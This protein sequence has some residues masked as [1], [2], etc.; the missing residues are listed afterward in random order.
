VADTY[1]VIVVGARCAGSATSYLLARQGYLVLLI[2]QA[3]FPSDTLSTHFLQPCGVRQ[4]RQWGLLPDLVATGAPAVSGMRVVI[5]GTVIAGT[6]RT[7]NGELAPGYC[8]RRT[9]LDDLLLRT[10]AG[11]G[12]VVRERCKVTG[13]EWEDDRV[14]G[15]R[16]RTGTGE[17]VVRAPLVVGAD[18]MRSTVAAQVGAD[19]YR[20]TDPLTCVYY[21]YWAGLETDGGELRAA[22][23]VGAGVYPTNDGLTCVAVAWPYEEFAAF[24]ADIEDNFQRSLSRLGDLGERAEA[25]VRAERFR[26]TRDVPNFFRIGAGPGWALVGDAGHHK[27]PITGQGM[28]DAFHDAELL[29]TIADRELRATGRFDGA[30]Y[31]AARNAAASEQH[32]MTCRI[33]VLRPTL[34][35]SAAFFRAVAADQALAD[36]YIELAGGLRALPDFLGQC[37]VR[38]LLSR[39]ATVAAVAP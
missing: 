6:A 26:G 25:A 39:D 32:E 2:D 27:D 24:R 7:A 3:T 17:E 22:A 21:S 35:Q 16:V 30:G 13:V 38:G 8:V 19:T 33:A 29:A 37:A 10:A 36:A 12:A 20:A 23:G 11:A 28:S 14:V 18:G 15:V 1:D 5:D 9:I 31:E 4:L 34:P